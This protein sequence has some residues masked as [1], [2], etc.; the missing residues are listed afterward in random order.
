MPRQQF[1]SAGGVSGR[2]YD[3]IAI[4]DFHFPGG[5]ASGPAEQIRAQAA[6]GYRTALIHVKGPVLKYPHLSTPE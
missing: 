2:A 4:G 3:I 5:A 1:W 6:A